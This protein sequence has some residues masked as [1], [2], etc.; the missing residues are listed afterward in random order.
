MP[1]YLAPGVYIEET[2]FRHKSITGVDLSTAGFIGMTQL[3]TDE[4]PEDPVTSYQEFEGRFGD[5]APFIHADSSQTPNYLAHAANAFFI[6]GGK[7]LYVGRVSSQ[8]VSSY[9]EALRKLEGLDQIGMVALPGYSTLPGPEAEMVSQLM[10]AHGESLRNRIVI[11]D[12]PPVADR[13]KLLSLRQGIDSSYA[14]I[15]APWVT[16]HDGNQ[17]LALP[18]SGCLAGIIARV[19]TERGIYRAPANEVIRSITGFERD[20]GRAEQSELNP[21][22]INVLRTLQGRGHRV[23]GARTLSSNPEWKYINVRR[24]AIY[25]EQSIKKGLQWVGFERNAEPLWSSV[26]QSLNTFMY[27]EWQKGALQGTK[28]DDAF[29]VQADRRTMTQADI[30]QGRLNII[31]G[32]A[33]SRP[34]EFT[35]LKFQFQAGNA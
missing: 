4:H 20:I 27:N 12:M 17:L 25:L 35:L 14:V 19:D 8:N 28:P 18:P 15:Y 24:Y 5:R 16:V 30:N 33:M 32:V 9:E 10:L 2:G 29:F 22:G 3:D 31:L 21:L 13:D 1:E 26:R 23:W 34:A 11:L 7:N 6:N